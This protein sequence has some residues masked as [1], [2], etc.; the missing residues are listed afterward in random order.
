[1]KILFANKVIPIGNKY[2]FFWE[3]EKGDTIQLITVRTKFLL[4]HKHENV[5][6]VNNTLYQEEGAQLWVA[7]KIGL[8]GLSS[9]F[10]AFSVRLA[11]G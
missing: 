11:L 5:P 10:Y 2:V 4:K 7:G 8:P 3:G 9:H 6:C 1:M